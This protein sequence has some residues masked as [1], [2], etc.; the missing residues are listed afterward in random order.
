MVDTPKGSYIVY[1]TKPGSVAS[2]GN[3]RNGLFTSKLLQYINTEGLNIEQVFKRTA[4]DVAE[5][6]SDAQRPWIASDYTGDFYFTPA[7]YVAPLQSKTQ[8]IVKGESNARTS[9]LYDAGKASAAAVTIGAKNWT[10]RNLD[11]DHFA[12]GDAIP[13]ARTEKEWKTAYAK[14]RPAWC[15]YDNDS[16]KGRAYGKLYNWYAVNDSRG[17]APQGWHIAGDDEWTKIF[18]DLGDDARAGLQL[19]SEDGWDE[20]SRG[21]NN[22]RFGALPG[23]FRN[24]AGVY[25]DLGKI[26]YWWTSFVGGETAFYVTIFE[27]HTLGGGNDKEKGCGFAVRCVQN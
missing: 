1:A 14:K 8:P 3:A 20:K 24:E 19:K 9:P 25:F 27:S 26:G 11:V 21:N 7:S 4:H 5:A 10:G 17:L 23:G 18:R 12:N 2:D 13:Q 22:S 15:Y 16:V 6:S